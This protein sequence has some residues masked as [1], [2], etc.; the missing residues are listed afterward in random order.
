MRELM[1]R[2]AYRNIRTPILEHTALFVRGIGEITDIVEKEMYSFHD[3]SDKYGD[4][5]HLTLRPENTAGIVRAAIEHNMLYDSGSGCGAIGPMFRREKPAARALSPVPSD[6]RRG[7]GFRGPDVDAEWSCWPA[8][9]GRHWA[10]RC[11]AGNQQPGPAGRARA[12]S[13]PADRALRE[14]CGSTRRGCQAP[15]AKQSAPDPGH[16]EPAKKEVVESARKL[17]DF[18]GAD[19]LAQFEAAGHPRRQRHRLHRQSAPGARPHR[20]PLRLRVRHRSTGSQG[21]VSPAAAM[22]T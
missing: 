18:L 21:T 16:Q 9:C 1:A 22:T 4:N 3:R 8:D 13:C 11:A 19:S 17:I 10:Y 7:A 5:D 14:A 2:Y 15:P 6:R 12:A 20:Q